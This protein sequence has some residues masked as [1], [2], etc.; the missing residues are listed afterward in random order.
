M[1]IAPLGIGCSE[2]LLTA[3]IRGPED[4]VWYC[5]RVEWAWP[6]GT[7]SATESDCPPFEARWECLPARGPECALDWHMDPRGGRVIDKNPCDCT[8]PGYPRRWTRN[9][10]V[11][12]HPEGE[13]WEFWVRLDRQGKT[14]TRQR[15]TVWVK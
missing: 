6:D 7:T 4:E 9:V 12:P 14:V 8:I 11:P 3:E 5:P 2:V 1:S 13:G 10:C 15:V